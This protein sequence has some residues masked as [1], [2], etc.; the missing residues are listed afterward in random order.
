MHN[1]RKYIIQKLENLKTRL[2][3]ILLY[4]VLL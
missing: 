2:Q 3:R 4:L 1:L